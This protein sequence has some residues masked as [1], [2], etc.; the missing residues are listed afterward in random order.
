[1]LAYTLDSRAVPIECWALFRQPEF[2]SA[3]GHSGTNLVL[4]GLSLELLVSQSTASIAVGRASRGE[5]NRAHVL[6]QSTVLSS[7][8]QLPDINSPQE[9]PL[10]TT[11]RCC[12]VTFQQAHCLLLHG[13]PSTAYDVAQAHLVTEMKAALC[14]FRFRAALTSELEHLWRPFWNLRKRQFQWTPATCNFSKGTFR[15]GALGAYRRRW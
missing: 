15:G 1:M 13:R 12:A 5:D 14:L 4:F 7:E 6:F 3:D 2:P 11:D 10:W 8:N 9:S